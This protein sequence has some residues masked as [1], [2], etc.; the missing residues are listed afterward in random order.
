MKKPCKIVFVVLAAAAFALPAKAQIVYTG[1][2]LN[3]GEVSAPRDGFINVAGSTSAVF[4]HDNTFI[5]Y[6]VGQSIPYISGSN[7]YVGI[8]CTSYGPMFMNFTCS[9]VLEAYEP[10]LSPFG[11]PKENGGTLD[12]LSNIRTTTAAVTSP[13]EGE[14]KLTS[15]DVDALKESFPGLVVSDGD[16]SEAVDFSGLVTVLYNSLVELE[17]RLDEQRSR[18]AELHAIQENYKRLI[19]EQ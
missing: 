6:D 1:S 7:G 11:A 8:C 17:G 12:A 9:S 14:R 4:R 2:Q 3:I 19:D 5:R 16:G 15:V 10:G 13:M 18:L